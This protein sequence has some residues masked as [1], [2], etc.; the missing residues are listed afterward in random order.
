MK[1]QQEQLNWMQVESH[2]GAL[3]LLVSAKGL[4]RCE[5][6][7]CAEAFVLRHQQAGR[8]LQRASEVLRLAW[9][10][11][12]QQALHPTGRLPQLDV[13]GTAFQQQV[14]LALRWIPYGQTWSYSQLAEALGRPKAVRAVAS[15][16]GANPISLLLPCHRVVAKDGGLGGYHWGTDLKARFLQ[17]EALPPSAA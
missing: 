11:Q 2:Y 17:L 1:P 12:I 8:S 13:Q 10:D 4:V 16:C 6:A 14:W 9:Q 15:A 5:P 3:L 7:L